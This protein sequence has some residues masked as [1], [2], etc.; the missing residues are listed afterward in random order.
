MKHIL[1]IGAGG[2]GKQ[3]MR[4]LLQTKRCRIS[5]VDINTFC[6]DESKKLFDIQNCFTSTDSLSPIEYH[7]V[8]IAT[9]ANTHIKYAQ[10]CLSNNIPFLIEKPISVNENGLNELLFEVQK[11]GLLAGVGYPRRY[12]IAINE[13]KN[14]LEAGYIGDLKLVYSVFSQDFRKYRP[15]YQK[16]YYAKLETGGGILLDALSHHID[17]ITYFA[18]Q[19]SQISAFCDKLVFQNCEGEDFGTIN[20]RFKNGILGNVHGNQFQKP[21]IDAI[22]F[23]GTKGNM[24]Y[25]R[26]SG[27]LSWNHSDSEVWNNENINGSWNDILRIQSE[28][29]LNSITNGNKFRTT[30]SDAYH[31]LKVVLAAR[32]SQ[33]T[34][35]TISLE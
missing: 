28:E 30:L 33:C 34:E 31:T 9:P 32:Q 6:L 29:F 27:V 8:I 20:V 5:C 35:K 12:S 24:R 21:N 14:R 18:G 19:I 2:M 7:G 13:L 16:T 25:E 1:I 23:V 4:S 11:K 15:D 3:H 22:E 10:W 17:L 26:Q